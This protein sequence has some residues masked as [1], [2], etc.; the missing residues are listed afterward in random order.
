MGKYQKP[1]YHGNL[2]EA[3]TE[4]DLRLAGQDRSSQ[5]RAEAGINYGSWQLI[6]VERAHRQP[7]FLK[8]QWTVLLL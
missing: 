5:K 3:G 8:E 2:K 7:V 6:E 1:L 4:E